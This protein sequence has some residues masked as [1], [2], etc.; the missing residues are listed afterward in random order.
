MA[1]INGIGRRTN[2]APRSA[3]AG[4][5]TDGLMT[6]LAR[7]ADRNVGDY[8]GELCRVWQSRKICANLNLL[9]LNGSNGFAINGIDVV[10]VRPVGQRGD[11][12]ADGFDDIIGWGF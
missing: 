12:T 6:S 5:V 8:A 10:T 3:N 7:F 1:L 4:D 11:A 2:Q 9:L